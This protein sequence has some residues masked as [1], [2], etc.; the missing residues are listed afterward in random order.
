MGYWD[1]E[2][3]ENDYTMDWV[4][5][6]S[7]RLC[8]RMLDPQEGIEVYPFYN[9][10]IWFRGIMAVT[11]DT[12]RR[13]VPLSAIKVAYVFYKNVNKI[14]NADNIDDNFKEILDREK[15]NIEWFLASDMGLP[16]LE[17]IGGVRV[18]VDY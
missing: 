3:F 18:L 6:T 8:K 5:G 10:A 9:A 11:A 4:D 17:S 13:D 1:Y 2:L 14:I 7:E 15:R 16:S 12:K